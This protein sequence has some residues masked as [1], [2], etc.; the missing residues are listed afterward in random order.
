MN[1]V[2]TESV[3]STICEGDTYDFGSQSL[4]ET[5]EFTEVFESISGCD[6][7]VTL[8]L[9]VNEVYN[10]TVSAGIC[11]GDNY[12]FGSQ[13]LTT[14]GDYSET[15]TASTGCDSTVNLS[16]I[17]NTA[18]E[19]SIAESICIRE[20]FSFSGED[21]S[22]SGTYSGTFTNQLGCDSLVT[23]ELTVEELDNSVSVSGATF[24][25]NVANATYQ[26]IDCDTNEPI[27]GATSQSFT[28]TT[29]GSYAVEISNG[30][31]TT[32]SE[33]ES[34]QVTILGVENILSIYPNPASDVLYISEK[35]LKNSNYQIFNLTGQ[36]VQSGRID[37]KG[38]IPLHLEEGTF[39]LQ[40]QSQTENYKIKFLIQ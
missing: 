1:D 26:W 35:E 11:E 16:L 9:T 6:S 24:S 20:F 2:Y 22:Q 37:E 13:T 18:V 7:T 12:V 5:G 36:Q 28:A 8:S 14:A 31:C 29:T 32:L 3:S 33:C 34:I 40:I 17:I 19:V 25:A 4:T 27:T 10:E 23:L 21:L 38:M 15:F 30:V 39:I